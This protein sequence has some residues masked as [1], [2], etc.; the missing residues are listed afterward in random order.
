MKK[1]P[2]CAEEIQDAAI[3]CKHCTSKLD[4]K[5][6]VKSQPKKATTK[7]DVIQGPEEKR[8]TLLK[9][10]W[11]ITL[12]LFVFLP[13]FLRIIVLI[14]AIWLHPRKDEKMLMNRFKDYKHYTLRVIASAL[15]LII[16][17][18]ATSAERQRMADENYPLPQIN[19]VSSQ[20]NQGDAKAYMLQIAVTDAT[21]VLVNGVELKKSNDLYST[22]VTLDK[23]ITTLIISAKN[24]KKDTTMNFTVERAESESEKQERIAL[25]EQERQK[26]ADE[27]KAKEDQAAKE[28]IERLEKEVASLN[29][30]DGS[31]YYKS[32]T[33][34]QVE[35]ALFVAWARILEESKNNKNADVQRLSR[36][37]EQKVRSIQ[38]REFPK[39]RKAYGVLVDE[40]LWEQNIDVKVF[41]SSNGTLELVG[42]IFAS[43]KNI[44]DVQVMISDIAKMLRFDRINY[45][46]YAYSDYTYYTIESLPDSEVSTKIE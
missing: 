38:L 12:L 35:V 33:S 10:L 40:L 20:E 32:V 15:I 42:A 18:G 39:M 22:E 13:S 26:Q 30:F 45:R 25:A 36:N 5:E 14:T 44:K 41:G 24:N 29:A 6:T 37:M 46:W 43:N 9:K 21:E 3:I 16:F 28:I 27:E 19:I 31:E 34:L 23:P 1:C 11:L 8:R 2:F 17:I 7:I 4:D